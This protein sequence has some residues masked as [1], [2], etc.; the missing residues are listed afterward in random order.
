MGCLKGAPVKLIVHD[1]AQ[2]KFLKA[3]TV[4]ILLK[5]K[6]EAELAKLQAQGIISPVQSSAW[7]TPIVSV[8]KKNGTVRICGDYKGTIN[9]CFPTEIYP[10]PRIEE[11]F[12]NL[13]GGKFFSKLDMSSAYLQLPLAE[14]SKQYVTINTHKGLFQ[15]NRLPFGV[16][17]AP[18]IFQRTMETLLPGLTGVSV[19]LDDI[20]ITG[21]TLDEHLQNLTRVLEKLDTSGLR[22]NRKKC[23]FLLASIDYLGHVLDQDGLHP[24][25]EK[26]RA[27]RDAPEPENL[28]QLRSFIG[29]LNYYGKFLPNLSST[30]SPLYLLL[31]KSQKWHWDTP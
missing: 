14:E 28:S 29:L 2:P 31:K 9:Q 26:I 11:L 6:V 4:P 17:S 19:Y 23:A 21:S 12:A 22:V 13:S 5:K 10:L 24:T 18:A 8:V 7:A 1:Q 25:E 27:I 16:A 20:L 3:R 30:L 15:F